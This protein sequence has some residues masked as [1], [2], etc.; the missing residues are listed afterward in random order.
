MGKIREE[1]LFSP[2][3]F[4]DRARSFND[5]SFFFP[6]SNRDAPHILRG[7]ANI[8]NLYSTFKVGRPRF[9]RKKK[10]WFFAIVEMGKDSIF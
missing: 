10:L 9:Q 6:S 2:V 5:F 4:W 8:V 1:I 7:L 3:F